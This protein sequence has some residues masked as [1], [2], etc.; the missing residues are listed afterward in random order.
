MIHEKLFDWDEPVSFLVRLKEHLKS[1]ILEVQEEE[2]RKNHDETK[3]TGVAD[4]S[5]E[6]S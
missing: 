2:D 5:S 4:S 3:S 1:G 6:I